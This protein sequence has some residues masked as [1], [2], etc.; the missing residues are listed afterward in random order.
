MDIAECRRQS[1]LMLRMVQHTTVL[2][3]AFLFG[4][5]FE[6]LA[7]LGSTNL[8]GLQIQVTSIFRSGNSM[9][10]DSSIGFQFTSSKSNSAISMAKVRILNAVDDTGKSLVRTNQTIPHN[11][12]S[13]LISKNE[14]RFYITVGGLK[15]P[16]A[17]A[18]VIKHLAAETDLIER[19]EVPLVL[20][21]FISQ[22][23]KTWH[24]SLLDQF[25]IKIVYQGKAD[26]PPPGSLV[27]D[28]KADKR[29][30]LI[31][32]DPHRKIIS[33]TFT[34]P[35]GQVLSAD[36]EEIFLSRGATGER[37]Y[38]FQEKPPRDLTLALNLS[39]SETTNTIRF[40]LDNIRL[41]WIDLPTFEVSATSAT[42]RPGKGTNPCSGSLILNFA[43]GPLT[44]A[45]GIR[46]LWIT[47][48]EDNSGQPVKVQWIMERFSALPTTALSNGRLVSK[49]VALK[50]QSPA[51]IAIRILKGEAELICPASTN[52][53]AVTINN[54]MSQPGKAFDL[55]LLKSNQVKLTYLGPVNFTTFKS[56]LAKTNWVASSGATDLLSE[57]TNSL[58]FALEDPCLVVIAP[59]GEN[60]LT[61]WDDK[62]NK[63]STTGQ[64]ASGSSL[65]DP[66][67]IR[68]YR[69]KTL[70]PKNSK[71][72]I[73]LAV[74]E[75]LQRVPF[76]IENILLHP[77]SDLK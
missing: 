72:R 34:K 59:W 45:L 31:V 33:L 52:D 61:F 38:C 50:F 13:P 69:F 41:P 35:S 8:K 9:D 55:P 44:N 16:A 40:A 73:C 25:Q 37:I 46:N 71:L 47:K 63:L 64:L 42:L 7:Q 77:P 56:D 19:K 48:M 43:G 4:S 60:E 6:A 32:D 65:T 26:E 29:I 15:A 70:P 39:A 58:L 30:S 67:N 10:L 17:A 11:D 21:N 2:L 22:A 27:I 36:R 12:F 23:G 14:P 74:P 3:A 18:K 75:S 5:G 24:H 51:P 49:Y 66:G 62:G 1:G 68:V 57:T 76:K 54:F 28:S 53:Y 20:T